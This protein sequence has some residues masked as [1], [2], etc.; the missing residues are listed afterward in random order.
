MRIMINAATKKNFLV[1][2]LLHISVSYILLFPF[3]NL[4]NYAF[5]KFGIDLIYSHSD[6]IL[7]FEILF[8]EII[9][10]FVTIFYSIMRWKKKGNMLNHR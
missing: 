7:M 10:G 5:S 8:I 6:M 4:I 3:D 9:I 1:L 2:L